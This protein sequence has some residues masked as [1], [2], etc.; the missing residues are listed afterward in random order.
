[1]GDAYLGYFSSPQDLAHNDIGACMSV[2]DRH[3]GKIP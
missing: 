2:I 1:M 3:A